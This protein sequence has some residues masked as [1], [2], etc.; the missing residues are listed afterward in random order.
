MVFAV[1]GNFDDAQS[2]VKRIFTDHDFQAE[3]AQSGYLLSSA[4]SINWGRMVPQI[5]YYF[6]AYCDLLGSGC[7][8]PGDPVDFVVPT[9]NFGNIFSAYLAKL[10]DLPV[11]QARLRLE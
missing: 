9:G 5:A 1:D 2:G 7:V 6:S 11:R 4:N 10:C 3:L 8:A